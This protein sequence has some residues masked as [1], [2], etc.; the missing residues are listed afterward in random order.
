MDSFLRRLVLTLGATLLAG[1][2]GLMHYAD[3]QQKVVADG[4]N[5]AISLW[6][7]ERTKVSTWLGNQ[8][9][10]GHTLSICGIIGMASGAV[11]L[12]LALAGRRGG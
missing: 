9:I 6:A 4:S 8:Y 12:T 5:D 3:V 10:S 2:W 7:G 1:G 11:I